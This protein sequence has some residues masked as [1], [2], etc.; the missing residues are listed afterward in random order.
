MMST[1]LYLPYCCA[2]SAFLLVFIVIYSR[3][4]VLGEG[5]SIYYLLSE[6]SLTPL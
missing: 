4:L 1:L 6:A 2:V 3:H 5:S